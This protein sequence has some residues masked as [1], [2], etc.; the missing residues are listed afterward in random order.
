M[1]GAPVRK[2]MGENEAEFEVQVVVCAPWCVSGGGE[3]DGT[4]TGA[5]VYAA[6]MACRRRSEFEAPTDFTTPCFPL[7]LS[8]IQ[9][10]ERRWGQC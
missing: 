4:G 6:R 5:T 8:A 10:R 2:R 9:T 1:K 7:S 3:W